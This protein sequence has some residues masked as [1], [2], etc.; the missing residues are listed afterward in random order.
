IDAG[1]VVHIIAFMCEK[2]FTLVTK[3]A[4]LVVSDSGDILSRNTAP[5]MIAPPAIPA[6]IFSCALIAISAMPAVDA[7]PHAVPVATEV[8]AQIINADNKNK[9]GFKNSKP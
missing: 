1:T 4:K 8:I 9:L 2:I 5:A 3:A 7:D 6:G